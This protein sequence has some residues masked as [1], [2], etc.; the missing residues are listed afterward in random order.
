MRLIDSFG[1]QHTYLRI[2]VTDRCNYRCVYCMPPEGLKWK[3]KQNLLRYEELAR[4]V[5]IFSELG[6]NHI[7]ITGGEPTIRSD[8]VRLISAISQIQGISD[9]AMTTNGHTLPNLAQPLAA[10]GLKRLNVSLDTLQADKFQKVTRGGSLKRVLEG[11]KQAQQ[12]GLHPIKINTVMLRG[13]NDNE[14][15]DLINFCV[16]NNL[17]L[18]FIEYMPFEKRW[19]QSIPEKDIRK[20]LNKK[21]N[22][23]PIRRGTG[24]GPAKNYRLQQNGLKIGFISPLSKKFC[25][26]CNRLRLTA[27]G[28]L[29]TCLAHEDTPSLKDYLRRSVPDLEIANAIRRMVFGKPE[30]HFCEIENGKL[31]EGVMTQIGG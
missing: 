20:K 21:Y 6:I 1:R 7:R 26:D 3:P 9:I 14:L 29:R 5:H 2:S 18:R 17:E 10:A 27:D 15:F 31:F 25:S 16:S 23:L 12:Y 22:L 30:G 4:L 24:V 28:H 19:H 11:I 13:F 8:I